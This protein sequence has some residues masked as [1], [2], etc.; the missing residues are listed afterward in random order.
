MKGDNTGDNISEQ[1]LKVAR[2]ADWTIL[3]NSLAFD[4]GVS[5]EKPKGYPPWVIKCAQKVTR[6]LFPI[7]Y[8]ITD[9]SIRRAYALGVACGMMRG[10][11]LRINSLLD[12]LKLELPEPTDEELATAWNA[13]FKGVGESLTPPVNDSLIP[14]E[15]SSEIQRMQAELNL[16]ELAEF[17]QGFADGLRMIAGENKS[18]ETTDVYSFMVTYWRIV[19]R[20]PSAEALHEIVQKIH[21]VNA[22]G[23]DPKRIAQMC[24][25]VGKTFRKAGRPRKNTSTRNLR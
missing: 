5:D 25:R 14:E 12:P 10:G 16:R 2:W 3:L 24:Q 7:I 23:S 21:G 18:T 13:L 8:E 1:F 11:E 19:D 17:H 15:I 4:S 22:A 9:T 6:A 20:L